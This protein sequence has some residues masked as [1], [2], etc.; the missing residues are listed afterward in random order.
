MCHIKVVAGGEEASFLVYNV[1]ERKLACELPL[2]TLTLLEVFPAFEWVTERL[3]S[4]DTLLSHVCSP[5]I[6]EKLS[7]LFSLCSCSQSGKTKCGEIAC[8]S[9]MLIIMRTHSIINYVGRYSAL[10]CPPT[11]L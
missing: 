11:T 3:G 10:L 4:E 8:I 6:L 5:V 1:S 2:T 9:T 7:L